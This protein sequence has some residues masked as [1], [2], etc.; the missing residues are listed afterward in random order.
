[1]DYWHNLVTQKSFDI[2]KKLRKDYSFILIGGWAI[3]FYT[4]ALK[5]KDVDII[6]DYEELARL[7]EKFPL[8]KNERL[9]KYEIKNEEIDIDIYVPYYS[10]P[11]LPAE[12]MKEYTT[13]R[14]G[15][16]LPVP[17]ALLIL[18]QKAF[19]ERKNS[20]KGEK[21]KIDIFSLLKGTS[22]DFS[23]YF[24]I[25]KLHNKTEFAQELIKLVQDTREVKEISL[26][27]QSF[28]KLR[29]KI[30]VNIAKAKGFY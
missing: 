17:E 18:K 16:H 24:K 3:Y 8:T 29:K 9:R 1:M 10:N 6:V 5:S 19:L 14:E 22:F 23:R 30:L 12:A 20:I 21:D 4:K 13:E 27:R 11:G 26:N 28:A 2:L 15:F 25:L 7:K